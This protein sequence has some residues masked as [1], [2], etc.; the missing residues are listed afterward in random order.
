[1]AN[2]PKKATEMTDAEWR[3][4]RSAAIRA[5][6]GMSAEEIADLAERRGGSEPAKDAREMTDVE[7]SAAKARAIRDS[8][9]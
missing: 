9:I 1:M 8:M 7:Y 3:A 6:P 2:P 4:A 5:R